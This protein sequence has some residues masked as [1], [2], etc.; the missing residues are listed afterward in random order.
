VYL[1]PDPCLARHRFTGMESSRQT[2][3]PR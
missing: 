2:L 1:H 3:A